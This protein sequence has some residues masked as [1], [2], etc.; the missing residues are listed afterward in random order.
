MTAICLALN[1]PIMISNTIFY[2]GGI[3]LDP[4]SEYDNAILVTLT[5]LIGKNLEEI[6]K[7]FLKLFEKTLI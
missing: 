2:K 7:L 6:N 1:I 5:T 4:L 3:Y